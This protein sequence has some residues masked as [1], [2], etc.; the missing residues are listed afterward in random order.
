MLCDLGNAA[1]Q[2]RRDA[3]RMARESL[4]FNSQCA[5]LPP[6]RRA[7]DEWGALDSNIPRGALRRVEKAFQAFYRRCKSGETPG[8]PRFKPRRRY[9]CIEVRDVRRA[10]IKRRRSGRVDVR[11]K[12]MPTVRLYP[13]DRLLPDSCPK[14][15]QIIRHSAGCT[16]NLVF[17]I[18]LEKLGETPA[19]V[20]IDMGVRKRMTL[21]N[22]ETIDA[23]TG[24]WKKVRR[25][26]RAV[27]RCKR[28][29]WNR[30]KR[31]AQLARLHRK[32]AVR[33]RNACH[34]IT[35]DLVRR[36]GRICIED[37]TIKSITTSG[38]GRHNLN[39]SILDQTWGIIRQ[40]LT[41][42]A[43][44]A[45]RELVMVNPAYT[46][47]TCSWCGIRGDPGAA[48][49]WRCKTCGTRHDRDINAAINILRAGSSP[50]VRQAGQ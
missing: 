30:R 19:A 7:D 40:Q 44:W 32:Q 29:S 16:V 49:Y 38:E 4:N 41:Y 17:E 25:A 5:Q 43:E 35:T 6:I 8:F 28:G 37:L 2:E 31:V 3:W 20:G 12:G 26:Q 22:G 14:A 45:G 10:N 33:N 27:S 21:S 23:A 13:E 48:E 15:L 46:S 36:F 1:I 47:R 39:R 42:K 50:S 24:D 11:F 9:Q 18:E 34:R